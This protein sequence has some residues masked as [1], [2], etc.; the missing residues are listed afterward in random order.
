MSSLITPIQ[1]G[2]Y[3]T[4]GHFDQSYIPHGHGVYQHANGDLYSGAFQEGARDGKGKLTKPNGD[5]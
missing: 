1:S 4:L 2:E 3:I 5:S